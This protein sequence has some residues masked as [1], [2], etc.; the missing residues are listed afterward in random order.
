MMELRI[1][2]SLFHLM[3][4]SS[5]LLMSSTEAKRG[6]E[7]SKALGLELRVHIEGLNN[8]MHKEDS[9]GKAV[10]LGT[11]LIMLT[12]PMGSLT[13]LTLNRRLRKRRRPRDLNQLQ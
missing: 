13:L 11:P 1:K 6:R 8:T 7:R 2:D 10:L 9:L 3:I 12:S 5:L 4:H